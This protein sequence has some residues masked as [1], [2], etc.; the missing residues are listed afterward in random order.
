MSGVVLSRS[1][2]WVFRGV[3]SRLAERR[4]KVAVWAPTSLKDWF[5]NDKV[6][7][8]AW[9]EDLSE[10]ERAEVLREVEW[11]VVPAGWSEDDPRREALREVEVR[12][13]VLGRF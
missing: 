1:A 8:V 9:L 2:L 6:E 10:A 4:P 5:V 11:V 3:L 7:V 12:V 13:G